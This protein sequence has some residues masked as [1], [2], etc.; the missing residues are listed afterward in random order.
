MGGGEHHKTKQIKPHVIYTPN[1]IMIENIMTL[2]LAV[3]EEINEVPAELLTPT[4]HWKKACI[5]RRRKGPWRVPGKYQRSAQNLGMVQWESC[6]ERE[7]TRKKLASGQNLVISSTRR[8]KAEEGVRIQA[9]PSLESIAGPWGA[10]NMK[11]EGRG[12]HRTIVR[13]EM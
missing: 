1:S 6:R 12:E 7:S 5:W 8:R 9:L 2:K 10:E 3:S 13:L 11:V 4:H